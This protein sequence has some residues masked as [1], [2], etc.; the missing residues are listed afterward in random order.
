MTFQPITL[1]VTNR[2][3]L[4][5]AALCEDCGRSHMDGSSPA[6]LGWRY[7]IDPA[8]Q[9]TQGRCFDCLEAIEQAYFARVRRQ[10]QQNRPIVRLLAWA[11]GVPAA[12]VAA[13]LPKPVDL[14]AGTLVGILLA[15]VLILFW[16]IT[17]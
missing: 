12:R 5:Q 8:Q 9:V 1:K 3:A 17:P 13:A 4:A 6:P 14:L 10:Q 15:I 2:Q 11:G 7:N 16:G